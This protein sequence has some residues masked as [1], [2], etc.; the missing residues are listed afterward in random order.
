MSFIDKTIFNIR[1]RTLD[2][3]K[4]LDSQNVADHGHVFS[5]PFQ[6]DVEMQ[7][8]A[9]APILPKKIARILKQAALHKVALARLNN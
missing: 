2:A 9:S 5:Q 1:P 8:Q 7:T 6:N 3:K 4:G